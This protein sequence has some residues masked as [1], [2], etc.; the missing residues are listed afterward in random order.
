MVVPLA[1]IQNIR[2]RLLTSVHRN[3]RDH[4]PTS[5]KRFKRIKKVKK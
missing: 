4:M 1:E 2:D 3:I 5:R